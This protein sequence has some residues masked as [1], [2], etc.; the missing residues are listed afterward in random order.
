[1]ALL[2]WFRHLDDVVSILIRPGCRR[3]AGNRLHLGTAAADPAAV[4]VP[5]GERDAEERMLGLAGGDELVGDHHGL[6]RGDREA[7]AD[8]SGPSACSDSGMPLPSSH[9]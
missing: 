7:D 3:S 2:T 1:M 6:V 8:R 4:D 5:A 9:R